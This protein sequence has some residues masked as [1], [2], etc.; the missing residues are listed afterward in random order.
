VSVNYSLVSTELTLSGPI[1]A[2][3]RRRA[4]SAAIEYRPADA[5]TL[6]LSGGA[7]LG[8]DLVVAKIRYELGPGPVGSLGLSYR[9]LD[10]RDPYLPFVLA[11]GAFSA[12]TV[13]TE[14]QAP[15]SEEARMSAFD[16][17]AGLVAGKV[18]LDAFAPYV[19]GRGFGGP[20]LWERGGREVTGQDQHHFQLG[21]G[22]LV[23][24]GVFDAFFEIIPL[25]ERA[26]TFGAAVAF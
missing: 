1:D 15:G 17:R 7:S 25:G 9:I 8:G 24:A 10:G 19:V 12:S 2:D 11:S 22:A 23:T 3:L 5:W 6:S 13:P 4:I 18:F 14:A 26:A 20:I 21:G 16:F